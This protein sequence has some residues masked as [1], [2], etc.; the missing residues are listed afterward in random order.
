MDVV[1]KW[2]PGTLAA[3]ALAAVY[4][5]VAAHDEAV[6]ARAEL[7]QAKTIACPSTLAGR[8]FVFSAYEYLSITRPGTARLSCWYK[9]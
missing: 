9:S 6:L 3:I 8:Q 1:R 5:A 7:A 2:L 4:A